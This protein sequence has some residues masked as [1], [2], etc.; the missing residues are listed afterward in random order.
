M[1]Q[2]C[3]FICFHSPIIILFLF[4]FS[5][6]FYLLDYIILRNEYFR[7]QEDGIVKWYILLCNAGHDLRLKV[8]KRAVH[9]FSSPFHLLSL[10]R[11]CCKQDYAVD[12][13]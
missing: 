8:F 10:G 11:G 13:G 7:Y 2:K 12:T 1:F 5:T 4:D 9:N 6:N 3:L